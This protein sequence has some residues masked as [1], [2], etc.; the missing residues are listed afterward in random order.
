MKN[1]LKSLSRELF[2]V[3]TAAILLFAGLEAL[4]PGTILAYFNL[5]YLLLAWLLSAIIILW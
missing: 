2:Y 5:N 3:L 4:A 1:Y